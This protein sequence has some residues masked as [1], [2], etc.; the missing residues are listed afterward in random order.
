[1]V[2]RAG[3][4]GGERALTLGILPDPEEEGRDPKA[5]GEETL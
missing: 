1:M 5:H 4:G 2:N 3:L